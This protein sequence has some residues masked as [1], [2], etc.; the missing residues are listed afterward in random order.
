MKNQKRSNKNQNPT[1]LLNIGSCSK[2]KTDFMLEI[3]KLIFYKT[4]IKVNGINCTVNGPQKNIL[5]S[6]EKIPVMVVCAK[7]K[8]VNKRTMEINVYSKKQ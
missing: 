5:S 7:C 4:P 2:C 1:T 6:E 8:A 3:D